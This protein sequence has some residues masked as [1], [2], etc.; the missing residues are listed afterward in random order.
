MAIGKNSSLPKDCSVC[1]GT[2]KV[3]CPDRGG[4]GKPYDCQTCWAIFR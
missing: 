4:E 1:S 2:C 3:K